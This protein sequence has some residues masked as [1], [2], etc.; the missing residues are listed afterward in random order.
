VLPEPAPLDAHLQLLHPD[1]PVPDLGALPRYVISATLEPPLLRGQMQLTL[2]NNSEEP[3]ADVVLRLYGNA[4]TIYTGSRM[5]A[6]NPRVNGQPIPWQEETGRTTLRLFLP[7]PLQPGE[8]TEILLDFET[9]VATGSFQGYGIQQRAHGISV[10]GSPF[11]LLALRDGAGWRVPA[12]PAVGDAASSPTALWDLFLEVPDDLTLVTTGQTLPTENSLTH[13]ASGPAR[14]VALVA[15]PAGMQP[16]ESTVAGVQ[17]RYWPATYVHSEAF[18]AGDAA[19]VAARSIEAFT[20]DFGPPPYAQL[21]VVEAQVPIGGYEYPGLVLFDG[22]RRAQADRAG[23]DFLVP[24][25]VAHQWFYALLGNDVTREPWIDEGLATFAQLRYLLRA[26]GADAMA[27]QRQR[28]ESEYA[29]A[30]ARRPVG[31]NR[32]LFGYSD[33]V[34]YRGPTYYASAILFDDLRQRLGDAPFREAVRRLTTQ[35]AFEEVTT[36]EVQATFD[37]VAAENGVN[38]SDFWPRW[39]EK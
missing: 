26:R 14:D 31:V 7:E 5:A 2:P 28:W 34:S 35:Y 4:R 15:L 37:E 11:P 23:I 3:L 24:H 6:T 10:F 27:A 33:W 29:G 22:Q 20:A 13:I 32:P 12:I 8:S 21:D 16:I 39:L 1:L 9:E 25:E 36:A 18:P 17:L 19:V 38:L 30:L